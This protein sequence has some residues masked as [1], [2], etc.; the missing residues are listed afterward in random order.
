MGKKQR[1]Q[2]TAEE[3]KNINKNSGGDYWKRQP[4]NKGWD[5]MTFEEREAER[6]KKKKERV[7]TKSFWTKQTFGPASEVKIIDPKDYEPDG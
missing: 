3:I 1:R 6:S 5:S 7:Q 2:R 4:K